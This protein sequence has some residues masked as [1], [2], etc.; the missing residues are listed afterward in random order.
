MSLSPS[1]SFNKVTIV[2]LEWVQDSLP[3]PFALA[4]SVTIE[5]LTGSLKAEQFELWREHLSKK[6]RDDLATVRMALVHRFFSPEHVGKNEQ[7]STELLYHVFIA[8]RVVKPTRMRYSS[9]QCKTL[10]AG[11]VDVFSVAHPQNTPINTPEA[12]SLNRV[13]AEDMVT[14]RKILPR[15]L[16][17]AQNGP[18]HLQRAIRYYETAYSQIYDPVIQFLTWATG[19]EAAVSSKDSPIGRSHLLNR[20]YELLDGSTWVYESSALNEFLELPRLSIRDVLPEIL[21]LRSRV[22]HG[23]RW[24]DW[25]PGV[26]RTTL[27]GDQLNYSEILRE[28]APFV[29]RKLIVA[30]LTASEKSEIPRR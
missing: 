5:N 29:L 9:V 24:P 12:E 1:A 14:L 16:V 27:A 15:F 17:V 19:I 11:S 28:A 6:E 13:S 30:C 22:A 3:L 21:T 10:Q 20:I 2:P 7:H 8:L 23:G 25:K 26:T 18:E 4:D